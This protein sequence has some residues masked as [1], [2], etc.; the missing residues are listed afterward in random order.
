MLRNILK[1]AQISHESLQI[2]INIFGCYSGIFLLY[3]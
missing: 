3:E 1:K 2:A